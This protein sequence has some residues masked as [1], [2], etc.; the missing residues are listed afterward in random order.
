VAICLIGGRIRLKRPTALAATTF[1]E[2]III[3][4]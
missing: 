2:V 4:L 1:A 3:L